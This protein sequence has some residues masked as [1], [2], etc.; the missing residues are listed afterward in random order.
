MAQHAWSTAEIASLLTRIG[1]MLAILGEDRFRV[2]AYYRAAD[3]IGTLG[4]EV[5]NI[6]IA[7]QLREIPGVGDA[8]AGKLDELMATR[9][10]VYYERL[11]AQGPPGLMELLTIPDVGPK[12]ARLL[13][14]E[15]GLENVAEVQRAAEC[16]ELRSLPGLGA[17]SESRILAGVQALLENGDRGV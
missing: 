9:Y 3:S 13:W 2:Q 8:L 11:Q 14:Q 5:E 1:D 15:G 17:R 6:R 4:Q 7:G 12:T 16:G 10:L